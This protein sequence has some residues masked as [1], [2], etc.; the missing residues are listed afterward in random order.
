MVRPDTY[1]VAVNKSS[2]LK[3][4]S[5]TVYGKIATLKSHKLQTVLGSKYPCLC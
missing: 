5:G 2:C 4:A 1:P 3:D